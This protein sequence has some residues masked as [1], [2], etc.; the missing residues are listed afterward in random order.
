MRRGSVFV[1]VPDHHLLNIAPVERVRIDT[2]IAGEHG[3]PNVEEEAGDGS[4]AGMLQ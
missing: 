1:L 2:T 3:R 4:L